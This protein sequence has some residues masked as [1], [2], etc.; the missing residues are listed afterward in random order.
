ML[1]R[2]SRTPSL[3]TLACGV[4]AVRALISHPTDTSDSGLRSDVAAVSILAIPLSVLSPIPATVLCHEQP[5][6]D[7]F[8]HPRCPPTSTD[9]GSTCPQRLRSYL[10]VSAPLQGL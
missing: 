2:T 4:W 7:P 10:C 9:R 3:G 5:R 8:A 1:T 6:P